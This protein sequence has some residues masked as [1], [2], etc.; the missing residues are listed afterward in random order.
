MVEECPGKYCISP[1]GNNGIK[2]RANATKLKRETVI[3][4][5]KDHQISIEYYHP[6]QRKGF[7]NFPDVGGGV[8]TKRIL[9]LSR[10]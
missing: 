1:R 10:I 2:S 7:L 5:D 4:P 8:N 6:K 3:I 9:P